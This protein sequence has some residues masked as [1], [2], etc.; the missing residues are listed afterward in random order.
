MKFYPEPWP[1]R[2]PKCGVLSLIIGLLLLLKAMLCAFF[3]TPI[4]DLIDLLIRQQT[5]MTEVEFIN[6]CLLWGHTQNA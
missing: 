6:N 4:H 1:K 2:P 3:R 5:A